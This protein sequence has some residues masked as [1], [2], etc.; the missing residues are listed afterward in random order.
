MY[1]I[2]EFSSPLAFL[3]VTTSGMSASWLFARGLAYMQGFVNE[4]EPGCML[5]T[6]PTPSASLPHCTPTSFPCNPMLLAQGPGNSHGSYHVPYLLDNSQQP[7]TLHLVMQATD[8]PH[9]SAG[10]STLNSLVP[11]PA[12]LLAVPAA[13]AA[14]VTY[15]NLV[16]PCLGLWGL[17]TMPWAAAEAAA[18]AVA[19]AAP[20]AVAPAA[21]AVHPRAVAAAAVRRSRR[22][23]WA[24]LILARAWAW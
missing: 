20:V 18:M 17:L 1:R 2:C 15:V 8:R 14:A 21:V 4:R 23:C 19:G 5:H 6:A 13:V 10:G 3:T 7:Q 12:L 24:M 16:Q 9:R 11:R 22:T